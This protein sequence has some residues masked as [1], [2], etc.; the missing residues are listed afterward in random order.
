MRAAAVPWL[1]LL[2]LALALGARSAGAGSFVYVH[3]YGIAAAAEGANQVFGFSLGKGG[4]LE[5]LPGSP[6]VGPGAA[7]TGDNFCAGYCQ[8]MVYAR[9]AKLLLTSGPGG[10]TS[11]RVAPDGALEVVPGSPFAPDNSRYLGLAAAEVEG[12]T[13]VYVADHF[14]SDLYGFSVEEDGSLAV[15]PSVSPLAVGDG[16]LIVVARKRILAVLSSNDPTIASFRIEDDG[17]LLEAPGSPLPLGDADSFTLDLDP[18]GR[19]AYTGDLASGDVFVFVVDPDSAALTAGAA[20]P[21]DTDLPSTGLGFAL[22]RGPRGLALSIAGELQAFRRR[23]GGELRVLREPVPLGF[24]PLAH[25]LAP[26]GRRLAAANNLELRTLRV[27][28]RS[29]VEL[30]TAPLAASNTNAVLVVER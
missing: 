17:S 16:P 27:G 24:V 13:F 6:F 4:A 22:M 18:A 15:L 8:T 5:P 29:V 26:G 9:R 30:D 1:C 25:G 28:A 7:A 2:A 19:H 21:V 10:V 20:N 23:K 14:N 12:A 11:W 3:D